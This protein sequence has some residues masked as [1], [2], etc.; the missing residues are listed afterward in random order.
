MDYLSFGERCDKSPAPECLLY[1]ES[2]RLLE[3][4]LRNRDLSVVELRKVNFTNHKTGAV[5]AVDAIIVDCVDGTYPSRNEVG[6]KPRERLALTYKPGDGLP[7]EVWALRRGFPD[8]LHQNYVAPR[9]PPSLCLYFEMW[10]TVER[11]WT[12]EKHLQ[13]VLW[14][15]RE[16]ANGTLHRG[17]Q[18]LEQFYFVS[19]FEVVLPHDFIEK[20]T[21][22]TLSL[23]LEA[24]F[25]EH[26]KFKVIRAGFVPRDKAPVRQALSVDFLAV[27]VPPVGHSRVEKFPNTLGELENQFERRG[28]SF[29]GALTQTLLDRYPEDG[30]IPERRRTLL[31][32][33]I[34]RLRDGG[35]EVEQTEVRGL[36]LEE[37]ITSIGLK[38]G[39][40]VSSPDNGRV[41]KDTLRFLSQEAPKGDSDDW[42]DI[43]VAQP[44]DIKIAVTKQDARRASGVPDEGSDFHGVL[45]GVGA[46]G[47][48]LADLWSRA[49]WGSWTYVDD[50]ILKPH[51][52]IRHT[53]KA[54]HVGYY[55]ANVV[56][57]GVG[58][59][60]SD[61]IESA[62]G[63]PGKITDADKPEIRD[64]VSTAKLLVDATTTLH[65]PR[66]LAS[67]DSTPR[68]ASVF[69]TPSGKSSVMLLED[70]D[71]STRLSH[72]EAQYYRA[73]LNDY[74]GAEHLSGHY[75]GLIVGGGCRDVSAVISNELI[76]LHGATLARQLRTLSAQQNAQ[77]RTWQLDDS[78]GALSF[79]E[80]PVQTPL[81]RER[82]GWNI[83]FD[84][85]LQAKF[86]AERERHLPKET[87][88][89]LLG[90]FD[91]KL[92]SIF[93]VDALMAPPDSQADVTGFTRG[94]QGLREQLDECARRTAHVVGYIGEWHS[95]PP[96]SS[97][98][99]SPMDVELLAHLALKMTLDGL[100][101]LMLIVGEGEIEVSLGEVQ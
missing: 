91:Q 55:K 64:A 35:D 29:V 34:P 95:H 57:T 58:L 48:V 83:V 27:T 88:G 13:R 32:L 46:L 5:T 81:V 36:L 23:H 26:D 44:I 75:G 76:Q 85:G 25:H 92:K 97:A 67:Q 16:T 79:A 39:L 66:D 89:V 21:D 99:S 38:A 70:K 69:L 11:T 65:A 9:H 93:I 40:L 62:K 24:V 98:Q 90:Y 10:Q 53:G 49:G 87:G 56:S 7:Y 78:T 14:W 72:L 84:E 37:D 50:D 1:E 51:N 94:K 71:R 22:R 54:Q 52:V 28:S 86:F 96:G 73:I 18:P 77:I 3:A 61:G 17:D 45:A 41:Y 6:I 43:A 33:S 100:P 12:P 42:R 82:L 20:S 60:Y 31:V 80:V 4:C 68:S 59:N 74:W 19:E 63:L 15:L 47:S 2:R 8:T 30:L 101:A